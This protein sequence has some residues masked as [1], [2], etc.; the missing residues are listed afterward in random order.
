MPLNTCGNGPLASIRRNSE[1]I[2]LAGVG[3]ILSMV[4]ST[5]E[6]FTCWSTTGNGEA[7]ST[8][9]IAQATSSMDSTLTAEPPTASM[10]ADE[11]L[12]IVCRIAAPI[13][14]ATNWQ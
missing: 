5:V 10:V 14:E 8:E 13:E 6:L 2:V 3:M 11:R 7:V 1:N 4:P 12:V 9:P